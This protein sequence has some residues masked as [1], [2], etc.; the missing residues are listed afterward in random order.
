MSVSAVQSEPARNDLC[1]PEQAN[2]LCAECLSNLSNTHVHGLD[3]SMEGISISNERPPNV[4]ENTADRS[5]AQPGIAAG[6]STF[7][8]L[9]E[10]ST[11][12]VDKSNFISDFWN[13]KYDVILTTYPRRS[14]KSMTLRMLQSFF[15]IEV[16]EFGAVVPENKYRKYFSGGEIALSRSRKKILYPLN[17]SH[18][19]EIMDEQGTIPVIY[20]D[21]KSVSSDS[22]EEVIQRLKSK[23]RR[24]FREHEYLL[25]N[26]L[27]KYKN[28]FSKY[29]D[30]ENDK[31]LNEAAITESLSELSEL[32]KIY[33]K[34]DVIILIDEYDAAINYAHIHASKKDFSSIVK[35]FGDIYMNAL[36][37]NNNLK[38]G[39]VTGI[40]RL[41]KASIFSDIN[42]FKEYNIRH[43][44][45]T[46][47]YGF[48]HEEVTELTNKFSISK[49]ILS[50]MK[51]WYNGYYSKPHSIYN[52]WSVINCINEYL[53]LVNDPDHPV[54]L[55]QEFLHSYWETSGNF[56]M[57]NELLKKS[58]IKENIKKL[59]AGKSIEIQIKESFT[60]KDFMELKKLATLPFNYRINNSACKLLFSY[61]MMG[62]YLSYVS[63][64]TN[65]VIAPNNEIQY[66][67]SSK[68]VEYYTAKYNISI[69]A[70][71]NLIDSLYAVVCNIHNDQEFESNIKDFES[72]F[73]DLLKELPTFSKM[74]DRNLLNIFRRT[75]H[76][77]EDL[78][79]CLMTYIT[80]QLESTDQVGSEVSLGIGRADIAFIYQKTRTGVVIEMKFVNKNSKL[81]EVTEA[82]LAQIRERE[83]TKEME[84]H[85][86]VV[87]LGIGASINKKV[88]ICHK[89]IFR[90][91][92]ARPN[93]GPHEAAST[94]HYTS[95]NEIANKRSYTDLIRNSS[96]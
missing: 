93:A 48:T 72:K 2:V 36:K 78:I 23:I 90:Q 91:L 57:L 68:I 86:D 45:F 37:N 11:A 42:N 60:V 58:I 19:L 94:H 18:N 89:R 10:N 77:N 31:Q 13:N 17:I 14:G 74:N 41:A 76:A 7:E 39:L 44:K 55:K 51:E 33:F 75:C 16:D 40:L 6:V 70:L 84:E 81:K 12:F 82:G 79:H 54:I 21:M 43:P 67:F 1:P 3:R 49:T 29:F 59:A 38:K 87:H 30:E 35:I 26:L 9:V 92:T 88:Y 71:E 15:R 56:E 27:D 61:M 24:C 20:I 50:S 52:I 64:E 28:R 34:K 69:K 25:D 83:Y 32:L 95:Q 53:D 73:S 8:R 22:Y 5:E 62:G 63:E 66:D 4:V 65:E 46:K 96:T 85:Y 80:L 47:Y